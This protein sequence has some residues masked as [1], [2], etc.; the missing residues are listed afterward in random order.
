MTRCAAPS[1][2]ASPD[3][4]AIVTG[5]APG[6]GE[7]SRLASLADGADS[8]RTGACDAESARGAAA[9]KPAGGMESRWKWSTSATAPPSSRS[10]APRGRRATAASTS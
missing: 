4:T 9:S 7:A 10:P 5:A 1:P 8:G 2:G 3:K 6:I